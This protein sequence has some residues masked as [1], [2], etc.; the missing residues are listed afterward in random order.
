MST[1]PSQ[2]V[3]VE[4]RFWLMLL[5]SVVLPLGIN[6]VL[7]A[8]R[9]V[10]R[11]TVLILGITLVS[12]AGLDLFFLQSLAAAARLTPSLTDDAF[13][14]S[15]ISMALYL[16]PATFG[17]IGVNVISHIVV[18]HLVEAERRFAAEQIG[19]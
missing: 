4:I 11:T 7:L 14:L 9:A 18:T 3:F 5:V 19:Q 1:L 17:G 2:S 16:I 6:G 8:K 12:I 15:E 10:S 13:F